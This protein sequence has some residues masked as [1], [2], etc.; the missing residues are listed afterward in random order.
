MSNRTVAQRRRMTASEHEKDAYDT[1]W[2]IANYTRGDNAA[3]AL[4]NIIKEAQHRLRILE[5]R[6]IQTQIDIGPPPPF[7]PNDEK[8]QR[9]YSILFGFKTIAEERLKQIAKGMSIDRDV[10]YNSLSDMINGA[11][12]CLTL[13]TYYYPK[14]WNEM[15][16]EKILSY[17]EQKRVGI[18]GAL[19]CAY[20]DMTEFVRLRNQDSEANLEKELEKMM[21]SMPPAQYTQGIIH[22]IVTGSATYATAVTADDLGVI[23]S[24]ASTASTNIA[25]AIYTAGI[26][27]ITIAADERQREIGGVPRAAVEDAIHALRTGEVE[28]GTVEAFTSSGGFVDLSDSEG[29]DIEP[30]QAARDT[31]EY[32]SGNPTRVVHHHGQY[33]IQIESES[34]S[35]DVPSEAQVEEDITVPEGFNNE[36]REMLIDEP[37]EDLA[38][39]EFID[40]RP[41]SDGFDD[42]PG[43][44]DPFPF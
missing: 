19:M 9:K 12:Y 15:F 13:D 18:A 27:P 41:V 11:I 32:I 38:D 14:G 3:A 33:S 25:T 5:A 35:E 29:R 17:D 34:R 1:I 4:K 6:G 16:L 44:G 37:R 39:I 31:A 24:Q 28:S 23:I 42:E 8:E 7:Q 30:Q 21:E 10:D 43:D 22:Q 2:W 36:H 20:L 26:D 40:D